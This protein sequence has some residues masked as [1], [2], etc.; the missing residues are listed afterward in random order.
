MRMLGNSSILIGQRDSNHQ[1]QQWKVASSPSSFRGADADGTAP[2][3]GSLRANEPPGYD[4]EQSVRSDALTTRFGAD[5]AW[6]TLTGLASAVTI[7]PRE[8]T[9]LS[10]E[11]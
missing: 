4:A 5:V 8:G 10:V 6:K 3:H 2:G 1:E 11:P 7:R 9:S